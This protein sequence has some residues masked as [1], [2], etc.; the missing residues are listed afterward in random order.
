MLDLRHQSGRHVRGSVDRTSEQCIHHGRGIVEIQRLH[1]VDV[2]TCTPVVGE[3]REDAVVAGNELTIGEGARAHRLLRVVVDRLHGRAR[4]CEPIEEIA[5]RLLQ[6]ELH[7]KLVERLDPVRIDVPELNGDVVG[8]LRIENLAE[9]PDHVVGAKRFA[10]VEGDAGPEVNGPDNAR[11]VRRRRCGQGRLQL[12]LVVV[13]EKRVKDL[14]A[15]EVVGARQRHLGVDHIVCGA[16]DDPH[17]EGAALDG[18]RGDTWRRRRAR[19]ARA[20]SS[21]QRAKSQPRA[22]DTHAFEEIST[23]ELLVEHLVDQGAVA[24]IVMISF[25]GRA[26]PIASTVGT[27]PSSD[28]N[29]CM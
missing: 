20:T 27:Y 13:F 26:P 16:A 18:R 1:L 19:T 17:A 6:S 7:R 15:S 22:N 8:E 28:R 23:C 4:I 11:G 12:V 9:R 14:T 2:R 5:V 21:K 29:A 10:V 3:R 25:H 24:P